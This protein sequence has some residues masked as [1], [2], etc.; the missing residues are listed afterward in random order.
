MKEEHT[1][2]ENNTDDLDRDEDGDDDDSSDFGE[3]DDE[4]LRSKKTNGK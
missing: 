1:Q 3:D 4:D 2:G